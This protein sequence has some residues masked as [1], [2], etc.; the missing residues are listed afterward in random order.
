MTERQSCGEYS[1][2]PLLS[3]G[4]QVEKKQWFCL[5]ATRLLRSHK[6]NLIL[7]S[8]EFVTGLI[9]NLLMKPSAYLHLILIMLLSFLLVYLPFYS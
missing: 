7:L 2:V 1:S 9:C 5:I 3:P 4:V 6:A 8:W